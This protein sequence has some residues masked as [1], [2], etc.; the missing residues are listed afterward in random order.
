MAWRTRLS[1]RGPLVL[2]I[3]TMTF[4]VGA[5]LMTVKFWFDENDCSCSG[6]PTCPMASMSPAVSALFIALSSLMKRNS[7]SLSFAFDPQYASLRV[8]W[9]DEPR[10]H[11][12]NL[13]GP[14][15]TGLVLLEST[16]FWETMQAEPA[17]MWNSQLSL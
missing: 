10:F 7:T 1:A 16:D 12:E 9:R 15:P 13:K 17:P 8:S 11:A 6:P 3:E 4:P 14:V 5:P 2:L